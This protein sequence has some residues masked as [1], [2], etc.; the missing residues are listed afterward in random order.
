MA[1][2]RRALYSQQVRTEAKKRKAESDGPTGLTALPR[3]FQA[4][5][6]EERAANRRRQI[7]ARTPKD[8]KGG[9]SPVKTRSVDGFEP[10][11]PA[12]TLPPRLDLRKVRDQ[13][14]EELQVFEGD[15][16]LDIEEEDDLSLAEDMVVTAADV[17]LP[18]VDEFE[19]E[20]PFADR[21][22]S[23]LDLGFD[24]I[25][26]ILKFRIEPALRK[27]K[28]VDSTQPLVRLSDRMQG[29]LNNVL[30]P[31]LDRLIEMYE[32]ALEDEV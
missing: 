19:T 32:E 13:G 16:D 24:E 12:V 5:E 14:E 15:P 17:G 29:H 22:L 11:P 9:T 25:A 2:R 8:D 31:N 20:M 10:R 4:P 28:G 21:Q 7:E 30:I 26:S 1:R 6:D 27:L 23:A 3:V 18:E